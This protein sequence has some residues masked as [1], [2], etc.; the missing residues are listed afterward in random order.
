[1]HHLFK[2]I[3]IL[4]ALAPAFVMGQI[5]PKK[6][7][8]VPKGLNY[9][10]AKKQKFDSKGKA[11]E[12]I[13]TKRLL[14]FSET[15]INITAQ[16]YRAI[17]DEK[18]RLK[19]VEKACGDWFEMIQLI[20]TQVKFNNK[21]S[22][23][24]E[25]DNI[26]ANAGIF[27][28]FHAMRVFNTTAGA[29]EAASELKSLEELRATL[30]ELLYRRGGEVICGP[31]KSVSIHNPV[32][33]LLVRYQSW[34]HQRTAP[35]DIKPAKSGDLWPGKVP[36]DAQRVTKEITLYPFGDSWR[37]TGLYAA[38][39]EL[40]TI[41][42]P[43][44]KGN[45]TVQ[46][47]C[48]TDAIDPKIQACDDNGKPDKEIP[49]NL[50]K[51]KMGW[52]RATDS[53]AL[54][55]WPNM[56]RRFHVGKKRI[57]V[58]NALGGPLYFMW[59]GG[60]KPMKVTVSGCVE[61]PHFRLGID[62]E[63][64]WNSSIK[65][66]PA[67]WAE[68][69]TKNLTITV[70]AEN[71][72]KVKNIVALAQWWGKAVAIQHRLAGR[73]LPTDAEAKNFRPDAT[74]YS[75][76]NKY[77]TLVSDGP[78]DDEINYRELKKRKQEAKK[79]GLDPK[80][81]DDYDIAGE[82]KV[83]ER[84][85][86]KPLHYETEGRSGG[87]ERIVDD[88][89]ISIGAGHSGYPVMC[90]MWGGGMCSLDAVQR[91]GNW[92]AMH[93]IGHNMGQGANGIYALPGNGEVICNMFGCA[94]MNLVNGTPLP[95]IIS[96]AWD[97]VATEVNADKKDLWM[98]IDVFGR[99]IFYL[100]IADFFG[101]QTWMEAVKDH[102]QY[103]KGAIGDRM[104]CT[105]SKITERDFTPYFEIWGIPLSKGA[106]TYTN[107]W[108]PWP[109]ADEKAELFK[110]RDRYGQETIKGISNPEDVKTRWELDRAPKIKLNQSVQ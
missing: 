36:D 31:G 91:E 89:Q 72:R 64:E 37:N 48:H 88:I 11:I 18:E 101:W 56:V 77:G 58:A 59:S 76:D 71:L 47:G 79:A 98:S 69:E 61:M 30:D 3:I 27:S 35:E 82:K 9:Y 107:K 57:K 51:V 16:E 1:M 33:L 103:P 60:D 86:T 5:A 23:F 22:A 21:P 100:T 97:T 67:P 66:R 80:K 99:L 20:D 40:I 73:S 74:N 90:I 93:E 46:I 26:Q 12:Q 95:N 39:G 53:R 29:A 75:I 81:Y 63:E 32:D 45:L 102:G 104:C 38:P 52:Q 85:A 6:K 65:H 14:D 42:T 34:K 110:K 87:R 55:R 68:I 13:D 70:R 96:Y 19:K 108:I 2:A 49:L 106:Y 94:V 28:Y 7:T 4:A 62:S 17:L 50:M 92:G 109:T 105:L 43:G 41:E 78:K 25:L 8:E 84:R 15:G 83:V 24:P 44:L 54:T 10:N